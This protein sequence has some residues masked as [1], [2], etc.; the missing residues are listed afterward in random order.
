M[1]NKDIRAA[2][3]AEL[4][5]QRIDAGKKIY[6]P[7]QLNKAIDKALSKY[8]GPRKSARNEAKA[9][10]VDERE[11]IEYT[12]GYQAAPNAD[13]KRSDHTGEF[14]ATRQDFTALVTDSAGRVRSTTTNAQRTKLL[15]LHV[16]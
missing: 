7:A 16:A 5:R 3:G 15:E 1:N 11:N 8:T 9:R 2:V 6:S 14:A 10:T 13:R 12:D 4:Q